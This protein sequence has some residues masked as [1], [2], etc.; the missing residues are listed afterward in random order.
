MHAKAKSKLASSRC[1]IQD[2][3]RDLRE[4]WE[5]ALADGFPPGFMGASTEEWLE[6]V[7]S[8]V[9]LQADEQVLWALGAS[10]ISSHMRLIA[11]SST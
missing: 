2:K 8:E 11:N 5:A 9:V 6:K 7:G 3:I 1:I 4:S 10:L